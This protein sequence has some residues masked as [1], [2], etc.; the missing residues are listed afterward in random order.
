MRPAAL[1]LALISVS[2]PV[3]AQLTTGIVEGTLVD[4]VG[5]PQSGITMTATGTP[6][7]LV[8]ST[9]SGSAGAFKLVLPGGDYE[10][11]VSGVGQ[12]I[13]LHVLPLR[14]S[15]IAITLGDQAKGNE[16]LQKL[17]P[18]TANSWNTWA[19]E[20]S[21][22]VGFPG[23]YGL[24]G[25]LLNQ[26]PGAVA[27]PLDFTGL[28]NTRIPLVSERAF[29]WIGTAYGFEGIDATDPYQPGYPVVFPD[30]QM[31]AEVTAQNPSGPLVPEAFAFAADLFVR[32][33]TEAWHG[34]LESAYT[35]AT[36]S[37]DNLPNAANR[38]T[39]QQPEQYR[40][41]TRDH[42]QLGGPLGE[43]VALYFSGTGQW[44]SQTVPVAPRGQD[45]NS[46]LLFGNLAGRMGLSARDQL[47]FL[48]S[49]SRINLSDW[50]Q[51]L[52]LEALIGWRMMPAYENMY[53]FSGLAEVDHLDFIQIGWTRQL[54]NRWGTLQARYGASIAH[55]DTS[56]SA[57]K[58]GAQSITELVT[59]AVTGP[60]PLSN[61]AIRDRQSLAAGLQPGDL[62]LGLHSHR[63][64]IGGGWERSNLTT[65]FDAPS[66]LNL[67]TAA[68]SPAIVVE[69][70]TPLDSRARI[71]SFSTYARDHIEISRSLSLDLGVSGDFSRGSLPAQGSPAG[72]FAPA[73]HFSS[74]G[75]VISWNTA[76]PYVAFALAAPGFERLVLRGSYSRIYAPLAGRYLDFANPNSLS[77]LV[78]QWKDINGNRSF[79]PNE[80][81]LWLRRFGGAYASVSPSL[82]RP[83]AD[84]FQVGAAVGISSSWSAQ[85]QLSRRD[86][87]QRIAVMDVGV[88]SQA[89]SPITVLDPGP[90]GIFGTFDD[91][92][93]VVY[94]QN[95]ASFGSDSF[96]LGNPSDLRMLYEGVTG[97][98]LWHRR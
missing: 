44:A 71:Q 96:V 50:G 3:R 59:G 39:L 10:L 63:L 47:D 87:K 14:I 67:I 76:N 30:V 29:S 69:L 36:L 77:G 32:S 79:Q 84:Q 93:L 37:S 15:H 8:W 34:G 1:V 11:R 78:F 35:G 64:T 86:E 66:D 51:P 21:D 61:F 54:P 52:G 22:V 2:L 46:R 12:A 13:R 42:V 80:L 45:Q 97:E 75:N 56:S 4:A 20:S 43:R 73:R 16:S 88:P 41:F 58:T 68:G 83:Y 85:I 81:G 49:G 24:S 70:N 6:A 62:Q 9:S 82:N 60:S 57:T 91:S 48:V 28:Q 27:Q 90:D 55:L 74:S 19:G 72:A 17:P 53:G 7:K 18:A 38:G 94:R 40:W 98:L 92:H 95:P 26:T 31:L 89:Y 33:A 65:R 25:V 5:Q 23:S